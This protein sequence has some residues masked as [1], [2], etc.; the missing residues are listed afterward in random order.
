MKEE[1]KI[2]IEAVRRG[3]VPEGYKRENGYIIPAEWNTAELKNMFTRST[4]KNHIGCDNVLTI[5]AQMGL[6]SQRDFYEK[7]IASE[8]KSEYY[9][10]RNG[11]F[12]Y[13]KSY[14]AGYDYGAI[15]RLD[16]YTEGIVSPLYICMTPQSETNSDFYVQYFEAGRYNREIYRFA[17]EGARNHGLLNIAVEDF[18]NGVVVVPSETEQQKIAE[19]LATCDKVI[20]LKQKLIEELQRL[21]K[22]F[23]KKMFPQKGKVVPEIRF[24]GFTEAWEQRKFSDVFS[25]LQNNTLSRTELSEESGAAKNVHYGDVLMKFGEYLDVS[26]EQFTFI[27]A[28]T[29]AEKFK[30]SFL[31]NGDI[32]IADTAED[33]TVGKCCEI[34]NSAGIKLV[35]GLHTMPCRPNQKYASGYLGYYMNS[36]AYHD[37]LLPLMQGTKVTSVS[38]TAISG[39]VLT[40]PASEAEQSQISQCLLSIDNLITLHQRELEEEQRKKKALMQLLLTGLVRVKT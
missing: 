2:R 40:Y 30:S 19:I 29:V 8:D 34:A 22:L 27:Q 3:E 12:A 37:Q 11:D 14:S 31:Q 24:P 32:I 39:T 20:E 21:K 17:Q 28:E 6:I 23:M 9:L 10:M 13:N 18:F 38:K 35:S 33:E 16:K 4:K 26:K 7:D 25:F 15:K 5:S 1:I 36:P